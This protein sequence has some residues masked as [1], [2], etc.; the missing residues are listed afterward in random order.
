VQDSESLIGSQG[1]SGSS[2]KVKMGSAFL[3]IHVYIYILNHPMKD[4]LL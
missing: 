4:P 3:F 1:V 2:G